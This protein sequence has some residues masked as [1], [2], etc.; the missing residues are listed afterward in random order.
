MVK[1]FKLHKFFGLS[2]GLVLLIL[3]VTGFF[4]DHKQWSFL[5]T[6]TFSTYTKAMQDADKVLFDA[7]WIDSSDSMHRIVGG[8]RGIFETLDGGD[9]FNEMTSLQC[10]GIRSDKNG[11]FAATSDGVYM[12]KDSSWKQFALSG[13]YISSISISEKKNN[14]NYTKA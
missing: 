14:C 12:L 1:L 3:G 2:A 5:Y 13:E 11:I 10:S 9:S 4:I 7:Y 6:T 8:K